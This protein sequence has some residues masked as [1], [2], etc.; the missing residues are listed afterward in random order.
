[1][2][3]STHA[4]DKT[5]D[6]EAI[7]CHEDRGRPALLKSFGLYEN[8][9][10]RKLAYQIAAH[11]MNDEDTTYFLRSLHILAGN[12]WRDYLLTGWSNNEFSE[13][14]DLINMIQQG[15]DIDLKAER[16]KPIECL[17]K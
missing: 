10:T 7:F 12:N 8:F 11:E 3:L 1:M 5:S 4:P 2:L 6:L 16:L 14:A 17:E 9:S 15:E 13:F